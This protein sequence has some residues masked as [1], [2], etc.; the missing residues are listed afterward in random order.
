MLVAY[1][2]T[3][4]ALISAVPVLAEADDPSTF[5]THVDTSS[6]ST[7]GIFNDFVASLQTF[8][9]VILVLATIICGMKISVSAMTGDPRIRTESLFGIAFIIVGAVL[10]VHVRAIAS[11]VVLLFWKWWVYMGQDRQE[12]IVNL[13]GDQKKVLGFASWTQVSISAAGL[14]LGVLIFNITSWLLKLMGAGLGVKWDKKI[15]GNTRSHIYH[16]P[17]QQGY[18]MNSANAIYF[19]SEQ[20]AIAAGYRK[21]KR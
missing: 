7:T 10:V 2:S 5:N 13:S 1:L 20:E 12:L 11:I 16:V 15:V 6:N 19:N 3:K 4:A 18:N 14:I 9:A 17:G 8:V 21:S